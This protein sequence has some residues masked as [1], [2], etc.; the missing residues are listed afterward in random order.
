MAADGHRPAPIAA[1]SRDCAATCTRNRAALGS[2]EVSNLSELFDET[3]YMS[4]LD[5]SSPD[6]PSDGVSSHPNTPVSK[7]NISTQTF[8]PV[9]ID[10]AVQTIPMRHCKKKCE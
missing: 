10:K 5:R 4:S 9:T 7:R 3:L 8:V 6:L 2:P 1:C